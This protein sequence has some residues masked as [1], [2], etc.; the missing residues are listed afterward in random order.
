M[1]K[2]TSFRTESALLQNDSDIILPFQKRSAL[3]R[4]LNTTGGNAAD[5]NRFFPG[6]AKGKTTVKTA[7]AANADVA[8]L[9]G[10]AAVGNTIN[11]NVVAAADFVIMHLDTGGFQLMEITAVN[12]GAANGE[13]DITGFTPFDGADE[14]SAAVAA[15]S[16]V[17]V[18]FA[19]D[20]ESLV[21]G[22]ASLN[23]RDTFLGNPGAP[24]A[25]TSDGA[26]AVSHRISGVVEYVDGAI[27]SI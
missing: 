3:V 22:T 16:T 20:V 10:D 12:G 7:I 14:P 26:A 5:T 6:G 19:E 15:G 13:I 24:C 8:I 18:V 11:G 25:I 23:L 27:V 17:Y 4:S 9:V 1:S 21:V 2:F